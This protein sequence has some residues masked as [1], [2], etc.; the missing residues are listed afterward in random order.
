[1][2]PLFRDFPC[3]G[4]LL[5]RGFTVYGD[6]PVET[7]PT[8]TAPIWSMKLVA[9]HIAWKSSAW[10]NL[11]YLIQDSPYYLP[12][13]LGIMKLGFPYSI[14]C[15]FQLKT[16]TYTVSWHLALQSKL[17]VYCLTNVTGAVHISS[18]EWYN[19]N[20]GYMEP[21][22]P[23][24]AVCFDNGRCQVMRNESD[25]GNIEMCL[26]TSFKIKRR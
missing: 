1:M 5:F 24:L 3:S 13:K 12:V 25:E 9:C 6:Y 20:H 7:V 15:Y 8:T 17:N 22:C 4:W 16:L 19:G 23:S 10:A 11:W 18:I 2:W 26:V 21:N 14:M